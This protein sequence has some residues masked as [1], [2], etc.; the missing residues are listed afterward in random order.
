MVTNDLIMPYCLSPRRSGLVARVALTWIAV[1]LLVLVAGCGRDDFSSAVARI[2]GEPV[3]LEEFRAQA[4]F[5]GMGSDPSQLTPELRKAVLESLVRRRLVA[6]EAKRNGIRLTPEELAR[7]EHLLR[8]G[9]DDKD[10]ERFL[11]TQGLDYAQWRRVLAGELLTRKTL[12]LL[13]TPRVEPGPEQVRDYYQAHKEE[14][15]HPQRILAQHVL[16]PDRKRAE[17][18]LRL[19]AAG[20]DLAQAARQVGASSGE[21]LRPTWLSQGHMPPA[22]EK[23]IF[24]LKPGKVAGPFKS[25]YG[26]HVIKVL[27]KE[28]AGYLSLAQAAPSIQRRLAARKKEALATQWLER[29]RRKAKVEFNTRF[30]ESGRIANPE[31]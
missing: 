25:D 6:V 7:E 18:L 13:F 20:Q 3:S 24:A 9:V 12:D 1:L 28:P 8:R 29:L 23:K 14:F 30:V 15:K 19:V 21:G 2:D 11:A 16:L 26:L 4:A 10:F 27:D 31:G 22:L 5:M 17:Q